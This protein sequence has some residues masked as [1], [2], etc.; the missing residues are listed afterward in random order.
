MMIYRC[1][2]CLFIAFSLL[3]TLSGCGSTPSV[4]EF[5]P[6]EDTVKVVAEQLGWTLD[7]D[8]TQSWTENQIIYILENDDQAQVSLSCALIDEK[9]ILNAICTTS[10]LPDKPQ[11]TWESSKEILTLAEK[12]YGGFDDGE[13][14]QTFS[15]Q[16]IPEPEV[17]TANSDASTWQESL[18]WEAE[19]PTGYGRVRWAISSGTVEH[20]FPSSTVQDWRTT[21]SISLYESKEAYHSIQPFSF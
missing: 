20:N 21:F 12:L 13:I 9:R 17:S 14:Y 4:N 10:L 5:P 15:D 16:S 3:F 7:S 8:G 1:F 11:F 19:C 2:S 18:N 6:T